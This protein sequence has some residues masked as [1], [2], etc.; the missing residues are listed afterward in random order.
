MLRAEWASSQS[1]PAVQI[2]VVTRCLMQCVIDNRKFSTETKL[3][4]S[5]KMVSADAGF[6]SVD[7]TLTQSQQLKNNQIR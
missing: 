6:T 3:T 5:L 7:S 2:H 1:V 4:G